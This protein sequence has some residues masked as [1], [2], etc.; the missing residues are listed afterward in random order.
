MEGSDWIKINAMDDSN[1][2]AIA[3]VAASLAHVTY[4]ADMV[5]WH[6]TWL[7]LSWHGSWSGI[8]P[9]HIVDMAGLPA[10]SRPCLTGS[11]SWPGPKPPWS[12]WC[13]PVN[14]DVWLGPTC[15]PVLLQA[16]ASCLSLH[17][18]TSMH[19]PSQGKKK[20]QKLLEA[21]EGTWDVLFG[22]YFIHN[23]SI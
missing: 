4:Y 1:W 6:G 22:W 5:Y 19:A 3:I 21:R 13:H 17:H 18:A 7:L 12:W 14:N 2:V 11:F 8:M 16:S 15:W 23:V 9:L 20:F 10:G